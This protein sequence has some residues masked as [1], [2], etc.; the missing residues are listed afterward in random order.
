MAIAQRVSPNAVMA[1]K[2]ALTSVFWFKKDLYSFAKAAVS[3]EQMFLS[4]IDWTGPQ[5]K[6]DSVSSF[7]DRLVEWQDEYPDVLVTVMLDVASMESF[8]ALERTEDPQ[9]KI[10]AAKSAVEELRRHT[11]PFEAKMV[12]RLESQERIDGQRE[13]AQ[14]QQATSRRLGEIREV[15]VGLASSTEI[16]P[17]VRGQ[18]FESVLRDLFEVFDLD[19]KASFSV[20]GEQIDGGFTFGGEHF[21]VEAKWEKGPATREDLDVF[22][23][24]VRRRVENTL[25]LFVAVSG[26]QTTAVDL[27]SNN[28]SP[29]I[30]M[31][32]MD[33]LAVLEQRISLSDLLHR[34][35][36][37]ASMKGQVFLPVGEVLAT[38]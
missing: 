19:P 36:R 15:Y 32:G 10:R 20:V 21:I 27:H 31:D 18:Q 23:K 37:A 5:L 24:K 30:L 35:R 33:L 8:P 6:R 14:M 12:E 16:P 29:L 17:Q 4:G 38:G 34:K 22:D 1:L 3:N 28:Q 25:G 7:V 2:N 9:L 26:F 13:A 11:S